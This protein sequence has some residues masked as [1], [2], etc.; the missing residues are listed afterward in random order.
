MLHKSEMIKRLLVLLVGIHHQISRDMNEASD[1]L[2]VNMQMV[3]L[4]FETLFG[5][6]IGLDRAA[7][8]SIAAIVEPNTLAEETRKSKPLNA[9]TLQLNNSLLFSSNPH[10]EKLFALLSSLTQNQA[11]LP[12]LS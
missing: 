8:L 1:N 7:S 4:H 11:K 3:S 12:G 10:I 6:I 5:D 2:S 9:S